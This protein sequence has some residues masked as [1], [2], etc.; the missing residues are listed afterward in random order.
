MPNSVIE[1]STRGGT[2]GEDF[3]VNDAVSLHFAQLLDQHL[4]ADVRHQPLQLTESGRRLV[5]LPEQ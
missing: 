1:Y 3:A 5:N 4:F 2:S